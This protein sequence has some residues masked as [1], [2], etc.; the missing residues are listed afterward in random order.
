MTY[1]YL[2][3]HACKDENA[4]SALDPFNITDQKAW[5]SCVSDEP[6]DKG[7]FAF[8]DDDVKQAKDKTYKKTQ[9]KGEAEM[10]EKFEKECEILNEQEYQKEVDKRVKKKMSK[11]ETKCPKDHKLEKLA[12]SPYGGEEVGIFCNQCDCAYIPSA[13][14]PVWH[15]KECKYDLC[16]ACGGQDIA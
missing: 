16:D 3:T 2:L 11:T 10:F 12:K 6:L 9:K 5:A 7:Q 13:A 15:C 8:L 1:K 14:I 4:I